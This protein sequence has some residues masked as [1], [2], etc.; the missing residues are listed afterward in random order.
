LIRTLYHGL[1]D[2]DDDIWT[3]TLGVGRR[4]ND[5]LSLSATMGYEGQVGGFSAN[6]GPTDGIFSL[7]LG[8]E[9][10]VGDVTIAGGVQYSWIG[11]AVTNAGGGFTG[12][13]ND[14]TAIAA[15]IRIGYSF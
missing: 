2:Y 15:G 13:F 12:V 8:A 3:Y 1:I 6:L 4:I 5:Q 9:Y 11:D 10:S 14:N 7:G